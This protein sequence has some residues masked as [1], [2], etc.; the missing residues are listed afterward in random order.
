MF[1][2]FRATLVDV[3]ELAVAQLVEALRYKTGRSQVRF[4]MV[5]LEFFIDIILQAPLLPWGRLSL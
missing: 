5:S 4:P 1:K 3:R 2:R